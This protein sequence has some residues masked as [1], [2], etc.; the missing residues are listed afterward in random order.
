MRRHALQNA[1]FDVGKKNIVAAYP[2]EPPKGNIVLDSIYQVLTILDTKSS[3]LM[4]LNGVMLAAAAFL[5][6]PQYESS[7]FVQLL[8]SASGIGST[9]SIACCLLVVSVDWPFLGL[10]TE[11]TTQDSKTQLNFSD[12]LFHLQHVTDFRQFCYR[13]GWTI[14]LLTTAAFFLAVVLF[15]VSIIGR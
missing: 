8:V 4:R 1:G 9:F 3:A 12:E 15:F 10:V 13:L 5:L 11:E 6:N 7:K 2:D 14:S